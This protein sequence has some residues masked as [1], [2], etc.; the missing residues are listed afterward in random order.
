MTSIQEIFIYLQQHGLSSAAEPNSVQVKTPIN[1]EEG[2][3][4][5]YVWHHHDG[6]ITEQRFNGLDLQEC[7]ERMLAWLKEEHAEGPDAVAMG[8]EGPH[9]TVTRLGAWVEDID[10]NDGDVDYTQNPD[11]A[12]IF[13]GPEWEQY[14]QALQERGFVIVPYVSPEASQ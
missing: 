12:R 7:L 4:V 3:S 6:D 14:W 9:F 8:L 1:L 13:H 11:H 10:S 2:W 5:E